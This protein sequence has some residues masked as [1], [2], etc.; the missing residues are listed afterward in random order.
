M[1][2]SIGPPA[3]VRASPERRER[4]R[5]R[6]LRAAVEDPVPHGRAR[7][8]QRAVGVEAGVG[9]ACRLVAADTELRV[10]GDVLQ[11]LVEHEQRLRRLVEPRLARR[12]RAREPDHLVA[13]AS[14]S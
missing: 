11:P 14:P 9:R 12:R 13:G 8:E 7:G 4:L 3:T 2:P 6:S 1:P 5:A 10:G